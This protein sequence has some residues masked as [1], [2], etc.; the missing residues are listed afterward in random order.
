M[1]LHDRPQRVKSSALYDL[2]SVRRDF[3]VLNNSFD[4][5]PLV[6][7]DSAATSL[8]ASPVIEAYAEFYR[9][10][11]GTVHRSVNRL[12]RETTARYQEAR[13][14]IALFIGAHEDEIVFV[15]NTTEA[16]NTVAR[17]FEGKTVLCS[18]AN[19]HS[20]LLPWYRSGHV[21]MIGLD[22][23]GALSVEDFERK[24]ESDVAIV[25]VPHVS[26]VMGLVS[27][28]PEIIA[29]SQNS[30]AL[31]FVDGAQ[32]VPHRPID[33]RKMGCDFF[34]FSGHK[35]LAPFGIGVLYGKREHLDRLDPLMLGG[36]AVDTV[37][38]GSFVLKESP[39]KFEAG[40]PDAG[41]AIALSAAIRYLE[42]L[43]LDVV[44]RHVEGLARSCW[45]ELS[46]VKGLQIYGPVTEDSVTTSVSFGFPGVAPHALAVMLF[47]RFGIVVRSGHHCA[48][49]FHEAMRFPET[50][51]ASF[52]LYNTEDEVRI[53]RDALVRIKRAVA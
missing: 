30:G 16:I 6:Y 39:E 32:S 37:S 38:G 26:N 2:E 1:S 29:R 36:G 21:R 40:T 12:A 10:S 44:R 7:L 31:V 52:Y 23:N 27:P 20:G 13:R 48:E 42:D 46:G 33:V 11:V 9:S 49:P 51:R 47:N 5:K 19:H 15:R 17:S 45:R 53:L 28:L 4:D 41:G 22:E 24:L 14:A 43:D 35:M 50:L 34:A 3:A 8:K 25:C 18:P